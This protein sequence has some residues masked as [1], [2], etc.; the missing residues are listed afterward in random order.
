MDVSRFRPKLGEL[1]ARATPAAQPLTPALVFES[2]DT[3]RAAQPILDYLNRNLETAR[4]G[5]AGPTLFNLADQNRQAAENLLQ[6]MT[7]LR[8]VIA[9]T[10]NPTKEQQE[11]AGRA[12]YLAFRGFQIATEAERIA[13][14]IGAVRTD[15]PPADGSALTRNIPDTSTPD[16]REIGNSVRVRDV[17]VGTGEAATATG[18][19]VVQYRGF[20]ASTGV[21]FD[22]S[23]GRQPLTAQLPTGVIPGF[24]AGLVGMQPGGIRDIFI[25]AA[26]GYGAAGSPPSIPANADLVFTVQL[27]SFTPNGASVSRTIPPDIFG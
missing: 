19:A 23:V 9:A 4:A 5:N 1:E 24:A 14:A 20:L 16:F 12:G 11:Y 6:F 22:T 7:E 15:E 21:E 3:V 10:P 8:Q 13:A 17:R 26:Q 25:P 2:A 18:T 27:I